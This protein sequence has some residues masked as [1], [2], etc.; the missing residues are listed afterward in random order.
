VDQKRRKDKT[1][2]LW[3]LKMYHPC[4]SIRRLW[5]FMTVPGVVEEPHG[6]STQL[7]SWTICWRP[8]LAQVCWY[9]PFF[10]DLMWWCGMCF[11]LLSF[12]EVQHY[13]SRI[14]CYGVVDAY[15]KTGDSRSLQEA[16]LY[17]EK[18]VDIRLDQ[19]ASGSHSTSTLP[20]VLK[21]ATAVLRV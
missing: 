19:S 3:R 2:S 4:D 13:L 8:L 14:S 9:L 21:A 6:R 11:L 18:K 17:H 16:S 5:K 7:L 12:G 15:N 1:I 10:P 20:N